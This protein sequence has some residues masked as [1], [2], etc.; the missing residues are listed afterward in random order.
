MPTYLATISCGDADSSK[1]CVVYLERQKIFCLTPEGETEFCVTLAGQAEEDAM[2]T[3]QDVWRDPVWHLKMA[4]APL[5]LTPDDRYGERRYWVAPGASTRGEESFVVPGSS[6]HEAAANGIAVFH[7]MNYDNLDWYTVSSGLG[8]T[9][10]ENME[11]VFDI[12][13]YPP[14]Q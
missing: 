11:S 1:I 3:I 7:A 13:P 10:Q 14:T 9:D 4:G 8:G 12:L 5:T 6:E 2:K